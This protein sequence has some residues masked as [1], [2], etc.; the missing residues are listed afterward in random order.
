MVHI[1]LAVG[2]MATNENV[3]YKVMR[4]FYYAKNTAKIDEQTKMKEITKNR[5]K[6]QQKGHQKN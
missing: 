3:L 4:V 2:K 1:K 6:L 5:E